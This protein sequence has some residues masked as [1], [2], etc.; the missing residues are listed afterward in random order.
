MTQT[1]SCRATPLRPPTKRWSVVRLLSYGFAHLSIPF[2]DRN[3]LVVY[4]HRMRVYKKS[5]FS[6]LLNKVKSNV[7]R[8]E[9]FISLVTAS[10]QC[11]KQLS[12]NHRCQLQKNNDN[13]IFWTVR[14]ITQKWFAL[15]R[16]KWTIPTTIRPFVQISFIQSGAEL[17]KYS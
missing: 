12:N 8:M 7:I 3:G 10:F 16:F 13:G 2:C 4:Q 5:I 6:H 17:R 14:T 11:N 9:L 1:D 15:H